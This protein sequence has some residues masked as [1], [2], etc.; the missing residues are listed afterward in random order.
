MVLNRCV[1]FEEELDPATGKP[2]VKSYVGR[3]IEMNYEFLDDKRVPWR[4]V[5]HHSSCKLLL[6]EIHQ[7]IHVK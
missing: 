6:I 1:T 7:E 5:P 4:N 2:I 3:H